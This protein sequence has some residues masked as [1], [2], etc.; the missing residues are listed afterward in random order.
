MAG[1][2]RSHPSSVALAA[3]LTIASG[4][5]SDDSR[6]AARCGRA[7]GVALEAL[8]APELV[9]SHSTPDTVYFSPRVGDLNGD[10]RL[11]V[12]T[13]H[14]HESPPSGGIVALAGA[15][16]ELLWEVPG[17][18]QLFGSPLFS[19]VTGDGIEDV[20]GGG[21]NAEFLA[22][23]GAS[24]EVL[25]RFY[26]EGGAREDGW[27]NFYTAVM[28]PDQT[29]DGIADLL[30]S[31]GG[32][33]QAKPSDPRPPG[34]LLVLDS[35]DGSIVASA[36]TPDRQE[37]YMS[38]LVIQQGPAESTTILFGTGG[39]TWP[40]GLWRAPLSSLVAGSLDDAVLL[41]TG[42]VK[43]VI[44]PPARADLNQ[45]GILD[46]IVAT[47][48]GRLVALDG[49]SDQPLWQHNF[50][51]SESYSTPTLGF[52]DADDVP[53]AF[54]VFLRGQFPAY[55]SAVRAL[56]SGRDGSI[57]WQEEIGNLSMGGD[58]AVDLN[59]DGIDE[60]IFAA[61]DTRAEHGTQQ[62]LYL[63]D[64]I[65]GRSRAWG[66]PL[67]SALPV[68]PSVADL[69]ADG[70]LDL[71]VSQLWLDDAPRS[72]V[73]RFRVAAPAPEVISWG[74]YLGTRFDAALQ[75]RP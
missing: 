65:Q 20:F 43:G 7:D 28:V 8:A 74:G 29:A 19:D 22:V 73:T 55:T 24:G 35:T 32:Y 64:P 10:G 1:V 66:T 27:Y 59:G 68:S 52:F 30:V 2:T 40:G 75:P 42:S 6:V 56:V 26:P 62:Q 17:R 41:V 69:D 21:R 12:V 4:G 45:D 15:S 44:A 54:V 33:D 61:S 37:T 18:Q 34:H 25:W 70:C 31:N 47:F 23:D 46:L 13:P 11:E 36:L 14:G 9:W 60:V 5:C 3:V 39:E 57:S 51:N 63:L 16:G 38:P 49:K 72:Q 58:V 71:V 50:E 48:E 53:D 67:G